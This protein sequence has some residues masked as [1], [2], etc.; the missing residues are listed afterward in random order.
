MV[1][2][3]KKSHWVSQWQG[4]NKERLG[5]GVGEEEEE[6]MSDWVMEAE[7]WNQKKTCIFHLI[8]HF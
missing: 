5:A 6:K 3:K 1:A 7:R 4:M 8:Y 2:L